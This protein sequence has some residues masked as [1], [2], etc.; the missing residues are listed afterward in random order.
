MSEN[1]RLFCKI[2]SGEDESEV[3]YGEE[4]VVDFHSIGGESVA[5][6]LVVLEARATSPEEEIGCSRRVG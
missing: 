1:D 3:V 2:A 6:V 5:R 4:G